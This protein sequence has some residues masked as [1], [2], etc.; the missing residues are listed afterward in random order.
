MSRSHRIL[1]LALNKTTIEEFSRQN[2]C[3]KD[4]E[5]QV[6]SK[7]KSKGKE[8]RKKYVSRQLFKSTPSHSQVIKH[9]HTQNSKY[10]EL[11]YIMITG[12]IPSLNSEHGYLRIFRL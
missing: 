7:K 1:M 4:R 6:E 8:N 10:L 11:I 12:T 5:R 3:S 2:R 9:I